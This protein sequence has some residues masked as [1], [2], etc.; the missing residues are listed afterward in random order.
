MKKPDSL[1]EFLTAALPELARDPEALT[2]Y[3][4]DGT[5]AHRHGRNLGFEIRYTLN[6]TLLDYRGEPEQVFL[7]VI[8]WL[9]ANQAEVILN[10]ETGVRGIVFVVDVL[11]NRMVDVQI[12]LPLSE[13]V[14]VFPQEDGS[15]QMTVR[16]E[17]AIEEVTFD[18]LVVLRQIWA[19]G[20]EHSEFLVGHPDEPDA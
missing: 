5:L 13:A 12:K 15:H 20:G 2:I 8:L 3:I 7:P 17:Q 16:D 14:D 9:R 11:D 1:R 6:L 10:H 4:T 18:P 19:P